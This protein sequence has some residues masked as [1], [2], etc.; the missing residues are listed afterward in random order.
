MASRSLLL[1]HYLT[2]LNA[3][4]FARVIVCRGKDEE[5]FPVPKHMLSAFS[6][7]FQAALNAESGEEEETV[8]RYPELEL[9]TF[10]LFVEWMYTGRYLDRL[11]LP[12][13]G[14]I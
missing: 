11:Q 9:D 2:T 3:S 13:S 6:P 4:D 12:P 10:E 14:I 7:R 5:L 8:I 1:P